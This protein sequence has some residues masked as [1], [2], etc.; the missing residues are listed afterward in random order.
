MCE[1]DTMSTTDE[2]VHGLAIATFWRTFYHDGIL[3]LLDSSCI[4]APYIPSPAKLAREGYNFATYDFAEGSEHKL[5][6]ST[7]AKGCPW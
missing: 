5:E 4:A 1:C 7:L 6:R 3:Y 2:K